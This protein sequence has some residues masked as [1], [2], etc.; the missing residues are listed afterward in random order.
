[1]RKFQSSNP[2]KSYDKTDIYDCFCIESMGKIQIWFN[3]FWP[4]NFDFKTVTKLAISKIKFR[5]ITKS[6]FF[7]S[8]NRICDL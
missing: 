3:L 8:Q 5:D 7:I 4:V 6:N 2:I 1:M